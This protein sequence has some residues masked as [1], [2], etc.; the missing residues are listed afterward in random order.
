MQISEKTTGWILKNF[1]VKRSV[2][3]RQLEKIMVKKA[4]AK[5]VKGAK[6]KSWVPRTPLGHLSVKVVA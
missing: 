6:N 2:S 3:D 4:Q 1:C 5:V